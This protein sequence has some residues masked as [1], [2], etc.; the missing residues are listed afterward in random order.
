M[1][2]VIKPT[3]SEI[4]RMLGQLRM[5][6]NNKEK[7]GWSRE[8]GS[9]FIKEDIINMKRVD[10]KILFTFGWGQ[11]LIA[12]NELNLRETEEAID[13]LEAQQVKVGD[14]K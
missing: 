7:F 5:S 6:K 8:S 3:I 10:K 4:K 14:L 2:S 1:N 12:I 9:G 11:Q 13:F